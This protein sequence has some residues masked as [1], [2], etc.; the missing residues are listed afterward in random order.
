MNVMEKRAGTV[1]LPH[2]WTAHLHENVLAQS[3]KLHETRSV[4]SRNQA[5]RT[6]CDLENGCALGC[7]GPGFP[8]SVL[9]C[10]HASIVDLNPAFPPRQES[11]QCRDCSDDKGNGMEGCG[12]IS[13]LA[14]LTLGKSYC[15]LPGSGSSRA[16][17]AS[18]VLDP[19]GPMSAALTSTTYGHTGFR[20]GLL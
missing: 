11:V 19:Q 6:R 5:A 10:S 1:S 14:E 18:G 17:G 7:S 13:D 15:P 20:S 3:G 4:Q 12:F 8:G 9:S 16:M 2:L